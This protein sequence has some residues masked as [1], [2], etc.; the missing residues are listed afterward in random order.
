MNSLLDP[1]A[2]VIEILAGTLIRAAE[3]STANA[4]SH[5][6]KTA[7]FSGRRDL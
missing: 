6:M 4:S 1:R 2:P 3:E 7:V 5:H